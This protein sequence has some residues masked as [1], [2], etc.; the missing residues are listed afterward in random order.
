M[1]ADVLKDCN[2][3]VMTSRV[4]KKSGLFE[5]RSVRL[6]LFRV[7]ELAAKDGGRKWWTIIGFLRVSVGF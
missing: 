4:K 2:E 7:V 5:I 6:L 1:A 3:Q